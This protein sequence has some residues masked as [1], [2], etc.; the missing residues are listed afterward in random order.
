MTDDGMTGRVVVGVDGSEPSKG[1]LRWARFV[2]RSAGFEVDAVA[3][4]EIPWA[5]AEGWPSDWDPER[6]TS[7][8]LHETVTGVLGSEPG[9][10]VQELVR[11]GG[12]ARVLL[13]E[14]RDAQFLVVGSRG[15]GGFSGLLLGS[16]SAACA[17]HAHCPV[18]VIHGDTPPPPVSP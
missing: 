15:H 9:V 6:E 1:A 10:S 7:G 11:R 17:E 2:A 5:A 18:L 8:M 16:V 4:W 3:A 12:A 13:D 14:S